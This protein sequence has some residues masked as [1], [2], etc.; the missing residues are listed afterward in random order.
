MFD[1]QIKKCQNVLNC[2]FF[3]KTNLIIREEI[4][5]I[6]ILMIGV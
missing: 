3:I 5:S 2:T 4:I 1:Y 6:I